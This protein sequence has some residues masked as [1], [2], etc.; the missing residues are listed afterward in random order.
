MKLAR[1]A[2]LLA[3]MT[4][5]ALAQGNSLEH[6]PNGSNGSD[7]RNVTA[8]AGGAN[9]AHASETARANASP[10]SMVDRVATYAE[11]ES[12]LQSGE[13]QQ[14]VRDAEAAFALAYPDFATIAREDQLAA[15]A[16][17][18]GQ[19]LLAARQSLEEATIERDTALAALGP[20]AL[21]PEV[22]A[23]IDALLAN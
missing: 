15:L 1:V 16:S 11:L 13:L 21:S 18:E 2:T 12:T 14:A 9:A 19:A 23:Y 5:P 7:N 22:K 6:R 10:N 20:D 17:P 8:L 3:L 4:A